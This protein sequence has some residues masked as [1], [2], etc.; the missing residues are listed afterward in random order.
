[1]LSP[2]ETETGHVTAKVTLALS[3]EATITWREFPSWT[4]QSDATPSSPTTCSPAATPGY[5]LEAV[6]STAPR[7]APS[8]IT[9]Y[10]SGSGPPLVEVATWSVPV[11]ETFRVS[12]PAHAG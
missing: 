6:A 9:L 1:M 3:P 5:V 10:P 11:V 8:R 7:S 4:W 12:P 2:G